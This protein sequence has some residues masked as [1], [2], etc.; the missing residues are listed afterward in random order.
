MTQFFLATNL[1]ALTGRSH[2]SK[3]LTRVWKTR[4][5]LTVL[6]FTASSVFLCIYQVYKVAYRLS[7]LCSATL[8]G[9]PIDLWSYLCFVVPHTDTAIVQTGQHPWLRWVKV[10]TLHS[11]WPGCQPPLDIQ[12]QRLK[13]RKTSVFSYAAQTLNMK[14][15]MWAF[16]DLVKTL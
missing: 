12:P 3:V 2:T 5:L 10:H 8:Y 1:E 14:S 6:R 4:T 13:R 7:I 15:F 11:V 16:N 9:W